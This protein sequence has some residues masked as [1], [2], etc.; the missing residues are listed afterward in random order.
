MLLAHIS[1][2]SLYNL[3]KVKVTVKKK[4]PKIGWKMR[5]GSKSRR[6]G[7]KSLIPPRGA[8]RNWLTC[9][10]RETE[11]KADVSKLQPR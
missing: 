7:S 4:K 9:I 5:K 11:V 10:A 6:W 2:S 8:S 3:G 1:S